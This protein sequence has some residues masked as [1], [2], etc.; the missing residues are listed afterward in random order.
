MDG[1]VH[2]PSFEPSGNISYILMTDP[3][4]QYC[5]SHLWLADYV[6]VRNG[7]QTEFIVDVGQHKCQKLIS[8]IYKVCTLFNFG[9]TYYYDYTY[10]KCGAEGFAFVLQNSNRN[11]TGLAGA[12]LGYEMIKDTLAVEFDFQ[13][14]AAK[15]D[16]ITKKEYHISVI[17]KQGLATA[18]EDDSI[19]NNYDPTNFVVPKD[20]NVFFF[21]W[22]CGGNLFL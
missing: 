18:S 4:T 12:G 13:H 3:N 19:V 22:G 16:P 6:N 5:N 14:T 11:A 20:T 21:F 10:N 8:K 7:F 17:M 15:N 2:M 9:C 1:F